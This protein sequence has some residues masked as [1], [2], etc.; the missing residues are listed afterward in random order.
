MKVFTSICTNYAHTAR[1]LAES[2][3]KNI[4]DAKFLVCLTEREVPESMECEYFD[5]VILSKDMWEGNFNRYIYK[6][7]I[8]EAS[9]S[10]KG[11]F[12]KYIINNYPDENKF[13]YLDP[14]CFVYSDFTEL[15]ELLDTRPIILCPHLL[16][17]GNIDMELSSTAHGVYNLS[18]IHIYKDKWKNF[19]IVGIRSRI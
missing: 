17:P 14:D 7:A 15:R 2:V 5:D 4:P 13:V 18:L 19:C 11:H 16:Q 8:V 6:H 3:K 9:T 10:V 12:F 1:T